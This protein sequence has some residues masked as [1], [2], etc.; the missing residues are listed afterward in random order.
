MTNDSIIIKLLQR[1]LLQ[2]ESKTWDYPLVCDKMVVT[3]ENDS[4]GPTE[5]T[6]YLNDVPIFKHTIGYNVAGSVVSKEVV[7]LNS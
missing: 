3:A 2:Q 7:L 5:V 6:F 4:G 1:T